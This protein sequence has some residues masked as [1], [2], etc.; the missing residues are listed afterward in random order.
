M[1]FRAT[2]AIELQAPDSEVW[3]WV[4]E[5]SRWGRLWPWVDLDVDAASPDLQEGDVV[6]ASVPSPLGYRVRFDLRV[7]SVATDTRTLAVVVG[8]DVAGDGSLRL[9]DGTLELA[10]DVV[11]RHPLLRAAWRVGRPLLTWAHDRVVA[12]AADDLRRVVA[13]AP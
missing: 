2:H 5:P 10:W 11:I 6:R 1:R 4:V 9:Q 7:A 8:G 12:R 3:P 13:S